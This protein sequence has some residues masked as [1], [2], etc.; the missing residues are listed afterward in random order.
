MGNRLDVHRFV[1]NRI[2]ERPV[3]LPIFL[4]L[5]NRTCLHNVVGEGILQ[6]HPE[7]Q[8]FLLL[9]CN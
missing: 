9:N 7:E 3:C 5:A 1:R 4:L 2:G 8:G 6:T